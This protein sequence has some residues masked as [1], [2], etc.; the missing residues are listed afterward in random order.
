MCSFDR[1]LA[2]RFENYLAGIF[3]MK[4]RSDNLRCL[5]P[6]SFWRKTPWND[7]DPEV[8]HNPKT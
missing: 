2:Q 8:K 7:A 3:S 1:K 6:N 4:R 5:L